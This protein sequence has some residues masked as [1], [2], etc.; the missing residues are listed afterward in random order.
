MTLQL[1]GALP[2]SAYCL[3]NQASAGL[4]GGLGS[5][6]LTQRVSALFLVALPM[7]SARW[8]STYCSEWEHDW[9]SSST[10]TFDCGKSDCDTRTWDSNHEYAMED[11]YPYY[12]KQM[13]SKA[14]AIFSNTPEIV[15]EAFHNLTQQHTDEAPNDYYEGVEIPISDT[16]TLFGQPDSDSFPCCESPRPCADGTNATPS[17]TIDNGTFALTAALCVHLVRRYF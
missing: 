8:C 12:V 11:A 5:Y 13:Q 4:V 16:C 15:A 10:C 9:Y 14:I 2:D 7:A 3:G 17:L 1:T 6:M